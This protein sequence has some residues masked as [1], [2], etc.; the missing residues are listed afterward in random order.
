MDFDAVLLAP[1]YATFGTDAE[2]LTT[3]G[4]EKTLRVIDKTEGVEISLG[5][6]NVPTLRPAAAVRRTS[7]SDQGLSLADVDDAQITINDVLWRIKGHAP[8]SGPNGEAKG[9]I[10]L[11]L[12]DEKLGR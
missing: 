10:Y 1:I 9:E 2:I 11:L 7:L 8:K 5:N 6:V 3:A 12:I 4:D